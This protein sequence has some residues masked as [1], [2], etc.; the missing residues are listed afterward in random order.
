[1]SWLGL[2]ILI[3]VLSAI[4][5]VG[6]TFFGHV[7]MRKNQ[8]V[9]DLRI[10]MA[11][12]KRLE[13]FPKI[14]GTIAVLSGLLLFFVGNYG[15]FF[16]QLWLIGALVL[17]IYIQVV[18]IAFISPVSGK[19]NAWIHAPENANTETL[20]EEQHRLFLKANRLYWA[21]SAG[22]FLLFVFMIA[23]PVVF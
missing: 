7:L 16:T 15:N 5:G 4:I 2:L 18:V 21:A 6:P 17:Y 3:H 11:M 1:M 8:S 14:G 13:A 19:L 23:K 12:S 22:G 10:S 20:P 9:N